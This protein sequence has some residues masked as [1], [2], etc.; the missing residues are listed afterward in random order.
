MVKLVP[1]VSR[2]LADTV[3]HRLTDTLYAVSTGG[4][5]LRVGI[6]AISETRTALHVAICGSPELYEGSGQSHFLDWA[7]QLRRAIQ[8]PRPRAPAARGAAAEMN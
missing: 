8:Q 4:D 7:L 3:V 5:R 6:Q 1:F 2:G